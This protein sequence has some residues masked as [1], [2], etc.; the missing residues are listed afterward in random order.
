MKGMRRVI[1]VFLVLAMLVGC[2]PAVFAV[3]E[4]SESSVSG[5]PLSLTAPAGNDGPQELAF[6][7]QPTEPEAES[8]DEE[9]LTKFE[10]SVQRPFSEKEVAKTYGEDDVV[11]FIVV[12]EEKP[13]LELY[14]VGEIAA[15][16]ASVQSHAR[17]QASVLNS[18]KAE[19]RSVFGKE[20][21][22]ELGYTYTVG[23][24]GFSVTTEF[25]NKAEIEA[26]DGV[27]SVY[28]A[29]TFTLPAQK[30]ATTFTNNASTMI[31][32]DV[33]NGTG[34]TGKGMRI[35]ILDTGI[36]VDHPNF[37]A[38]PDSV[39]EDP[40][41][42]ESVELIWDSLNAGQRTN[43]LNV[44]YVNSKIP[45]VFNYESCDF[46]VSNTYAGSDHGTHVAGIAAANKIDGSSVVGVAPDAQLVV[47]QVFQNTGGANW[48]TIMAALE[49]CVRL[50]VDAANLSLGAAAGFTDPAD[51]MLQTLNLFLD[52]D[53]QVL[54]ASG[55]DTNN[56]FMNLWGYHM[57]LLENPD[58]GLA[59]T[60]ST[61][62]AALAVAS[63][64]NDGMEQFYFTVDGVDHGFQDSATATETMFLNNF[65]DTQL[66][67]VV[68]P[69]LGEAADYEGLDVTGKVALVSRGTTSFP[70]KQQTAQDQGAVACIVYNNTTGLFYMQIN[71]GG[72]SIPC[73]SIARASGLAMI[74]AAGEDGVGTLKVCNADVKDFKVDRTVSEFSSWGVTPDLKLKPEIAGVGGNIY[75]T[76]D[77]AISGSYYG[78]MS[79]TSMAT[80]QITG[81]MAV[82]IEYLDKNYPEITGDAQRRLAANLLMSTAEPVMAT[83]SLEY[84]PRAQGAGL[85][86]LVNATT[87]PAYLSNPGASES[88]PKVEFGD[89]AAKTGVYE[90]SFKINNLSGEALTYNIES[91]VL[92]ESVYLDTFIENAPYGLEAEVAVSGG[93]QVQVPAGGSV[94]VNATLT[95]TENDKAY[96]A[97]FPNGIYVEGYVYAVPVSE[98]AEGVQGVTLT[99]PMV[100]F[101]GDWSDADV[102]DDPQDPSL[103][104]TVMFTYN[105]QLGYNPYFRNG[106]YGEAYNAF[107]YANP[108]AEVDFGMLRNAKRLD[109]S[110]TDKVTGEVYYTLDG[111]YLAKTYY[112]ASYGMIVPMFLM[113][114][115]GEIWDGKDANGRNLPDGTAVTY[116]FEAYLDDGDDVMDDSWSFDVTLDTVAPQVLNA[117]ALQDALRIDE[118][119]DR[120]YLSLDILENFHAAAL[121]FQ[122]ENGAIMG[123]YELENVPGETLSGEYEI[124]G[125]GSEFTIIVADY[126]CN[127]TEI[128]VLLDLGEQNN[129]KPEPA[130]LSK[131]RLYGCETFDSALVEGGWFSANKADFSDPRN[132]TY[133]S[134]NRYYAAEFVNGYV[135][136][137][138]AGTGHLELITPTGTYWSSQV[139]CENRGVIG[140][141]NVWVLY[142][143]AL[144]HSGTLSASYGIGNETDATDALLAV[145]WMYQGDSNND[146]KDDGYNA[147]FNIKFTNYGEVTVQPVARIAGVQQGADLLTLGIT[148]EGEVYGIDTNGILYSVATA[149]EWDNNV[150][151]WGDYVIRCTEIGTT[152]FVNYPNYGG[153]NVIQSMGYDH[154][155]G[156]M[157]WY[158]H[159]Q[160]FNGATY[161]NV[162]VTYTVDLQTA[163]CTEV[164]TYGPGGQTC[165]FVP[166]DLT[167][168]LFTLGADATG[169]EIN[170]S[171]K[172]LIEGQTDRLKINWRPWNAEPKDVTWASD[173][174]SVVTVDE[175]GYVTA[176]AEG[177]AVISAS[178][179]MMLD[180]YWEVIDGNWIW[181]DPAP[182]IK[183]VNCYVTVLPSEGEIYGYIIED[184]GNSSNNLSW[185]TYSDKTLN[186]VTVI[187]KQY[188][189]GT[190]MG[191][192]E[193][194]AEPMWYGGTYYN[195]YVYT[196]VGE[197]WQ[198]DDVIYSGSVLYRSPVIQG[199]TPAETTIGEPERVGRQEGMVISAMS[200]DYNTGRMYVVENQNIGGLGI[201]DLDTGKV[202]M[203][204][205]PKGDLSGGV[206]IPGLCVAADGTIIISDA[207]ANLYTMDPD[208]LQT[209][210]IY[211]GTGSAYTAFYEAMFYDY[212]TGSIYWNT[213]DGSG[214]SPL[215]LIRLTN[216]WGY[217]NAQVMELGSV[218][219]KRGTQQTVLFTIPENEPET[220]HL[221]VES[222]EITNGDAVTGLEGGSLKLDAVTVPARPT[223]QTR[224]WTSSDESVVSVDSTGTMT[225]NSVGTATVTVSITNKDEAT[226]GGP[227]TDSVQ[228]TVLEAAGEFVAFLNSDEG[229]TAYYDFWLKGNDYDLRHTE[230]TE[231]MI[232]VYSLRTGVY[233]DGY[234]YGYN[235]RGEFMRINAEDPANYRI[236][237]NANLDYSAY[238]VTGMA[239]DYTTGT[240][241]GL[242]M[243]SN[244]SFET[245]M[246]ETHP[247]ELV[248]IDLDTG[249]MTTVAELDFATPVFALAC[250]AEG[251]L[252]AAG[253]SFDYY[254]A[255]TNIYKL[256]KSTGA[257]SLYT[258]INGANVFTG[259]SYYG[260]AQ[261]NAQMTYDFGTDRLY[262]YATSDHQYYY[263]S[264]GMYMVQLGDEPAAAYL[265]GI[266]LYLRSDSEIKYGDV[267]LGLLAFIPE[268]D[269]VPTVDVNGI[270]LNK[271]S[272]RIAVGETTGLVAQV[273]PSAAA[274]KTVTWESSDPA[275]ATVDE[276]GV[277][278]GISEGTVTITVTS[279]N[280]IVAVCEITVVAINGPQSV[281]YTVS[282]KK[283]SLI[284]F[285]PA[286]P[287]QTANVVCTLSG[288]STIKGMAYG[289][290]CLYYVLVSNYANYLYRFDL[291]TNRSTYLTQLNAFGDCTGLAYDAQNDLLYLTSGFYLFQYNMADLD[292]TGMTMYSNYVMDSDYCTLT[293][294]A[295]VDGKV[296]TF[297]NDYYSSAPKMMCYSDK[298]LSDR[299]VV[300]EDIG[301]TLVAGATD[302]TYDPSTQLFYLADPGHTIWTVD[303]S[304]NAQTVDILGDGIDMNGFAID[305]QQKYTITYTDGVEEAE[306]FADQKHYAAPGA[307]TPGF[308]GQPV[309][310]GYTFAGWTPEQAESV[311]G[312]ATYSAVWTANTYSLVLD[313]AEGEVDPAFITVT[314]DAPIGEL[315]VPTREGYTFE[316]WYDEDGNQVTAD[317]VYTWA[318]INTIVAKW[319]ANTYNLTLDANGGQVEKDTVTV[320]YDAP[321]GELPVPTREGYTFIGWMDES[322]VKV[323]AETLYTVAGDST[324]TAKWAG[325]AYTVT[326]DAGEGATVDPAEVHVVYGEA[327]NTL[328]VPVKTGYTFAGWF[329]EN[330]K[331]YTAET[332]YDV[333]GDLHLTAAWTANVYTITLED[334]TQIEVTFGEA[335]GELPV[336]EKEGCTFIG[337]FDESGKEYT[338]E[339]VYLVAGDMTLTAKWT[340]VEEPGDTGDTGD[341]G[342][343]GDTDK[344]G[345]GSADTGDMTPVA[346]FAA[347]LLASAFAMTALVIKR[348]NDFEK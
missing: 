165:L 106:K 144:D 192:N 168:D 252:Y 341:T 90:F 41:T 215:Y 39:L 206:Y 32:A 132:E 234:F 176:V 34:Y 266:S 85:A 205:Q 186:D 68:V 199:A 190:D 92:T 328:P 184:Y 164:G 51:D 301:V 49:D 4:S 55:N 137:Q 304:G 334:G 60:P 2:L 7:T 73:V 193:Y 240:L 159:S 131:D 306:C 102:F 24:T 293:G 276:N 257:L 31:G 230:A 178:A 316:G 202:D 9:V 286:L 267:Y 212:D 258:T 265:D 236:L 77:P 116:A 63:V 225:F 237:G 101:Y 203:L 95:L 58:I 20:E 191:G 248:T 143:M 18:V 104:P 96:L 94:T 8:E 282:A 210:R 188:L 177:T 194:T 255:S 324:L 189:T 270:I 294:V 119:A 201:M 207:V 244:Y 14:S 278:T 296:Y 112:N 40:M 326:L 53:I 333:Q 56:A 167:S 46:N 235:D 268:E 89:D 124:T 344:P 81:A 130:E 65:R 335:I 158:A 197:N 198:E 312:N 185:V 195:G 79:G 238:Q 319:S 152:D 277:V 123:K 327:V 166:N 26:M 17:K 317:T 13:Q 289:D 28:V 6:A 71:D 251:Q 156:I 262:L 311:D 233:Y 70:E 171:E 76:V 23:T 321:I 153:A 10:S 330:G 155:T 209:Q 114:E 285:N 93:N 245:W 136:A 117:D 308:V 122:S 133:D 147:L 61:Y 75:A 247:G 297:G 27:K 162:N 348:R 174:E 64:D 183:T 226:H 5:G 66:E 83:D 343:S 129:A 148:T 38:L 283:D 305:S 138:N 74:E 97:Q 298:Y 3:Q 12:T 169:M 231:S 313:A 220:I 142:D 320:T 232:A 118:A 187:G 281:A 16:T 204:G 80:P 84:S 329:D 300:V 290:N 246:D 260:N 150:G 299:T 91:S 115:Y 135:V 52:S 62:S 336:P 160:V 11:T 109:I 275:V 127:E 347:M 145:G 331:E 307:A 280:G 105:S 222:I 98:D 67:Y 36:L 279:A 254:A 50:E 291:T 310:E 263:D 292:S 35:A 318:G 37:A 1:S 339:T 239:L 264:Y 43:L 261:Y 332:V 173:N 228:V 200:F 181:R 315:P 82:L 125:F 273:R 175:Y 340:E 249:A 170:P 287:A 157:Y 256:D 218:S 223:V 87:T 151:Q 288:G 219:T 121:I 25:G 161:D 213:C 322:G 250:D 128:D 214:A 139:L 45:F 196:V 146:G 78:T 47:M 86:D 323:L 163:E 107:S 179:E 253:G 229:G 108:L 227:F 269:E 19:V 172:T 303:L 342:D 126:A 100:G 221:P 243:P 149:T 272:G 29:P 182:G 33:L 345:S 180:G 110:V 241:Y 302:I 259:S 284:S 154:N 48:A 59:G 274:D 57:S 99:L 15:Q 22:F 134:S 103:Y 346:L 338:A 69:G 224:T 111:S 21:S 120:A 113:V 337:W 44:S 314:Y 88:R 242:T 208:T 211:T 216:D 54:I 141:P 217:V 72:E 309:R 30:D 140:D 271:T 42:R 295:A 325:N